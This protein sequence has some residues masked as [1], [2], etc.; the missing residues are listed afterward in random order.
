LLEIRGQGIFLGTG[1]E[2]AIGIPFEHHCRLPFGTSVDGFCLKKIPCTAA[3]DAAS[4]SVDIAGF[5]LTVKR[6]ESAADRFTAP[7]VVKVRS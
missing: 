4:S 1:L 7:I 3:A 5:S 2:A 6:Q